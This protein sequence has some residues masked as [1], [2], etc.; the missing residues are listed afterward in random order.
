MAD[1]PLTSTL[2]WTE[3][4]KYTA[5]LL[6][7]AGLYKLGGVFK[8]KFNQSR[9]RLDPHKNVITGSKEWKV[10]P[11]WIVS[12]GLIEREVLVFWTVGDDG[13][14]EMAMEHHFTIDGIPDVIIR[15]MTLNEAG[16]ENARGKP[17]YW[18]EFGFTRSDNLEKTLVFGDYVPCTP[19]ETYL[20]QPKPNKFIRFFFPSSKK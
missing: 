12:H 4:I 3:L 20:F 14:P 16:L 9:D 11:F 5:T 8:F 7:G 1:E 13:P 17:P 10:N 19:E 18:L 6:A 2:I 15:P